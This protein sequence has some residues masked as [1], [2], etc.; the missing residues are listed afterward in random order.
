[1]ATPAETYMGVLASRTVAD[2]LIAQF[3]L[4][5]RYSKP[6]LYAT[7]IALKH[8]SRVEAARGSMIRISVEDR[9]ARRAAAMANAYVDALWRMNRRLALTTGSQRRL[10]FEQQVESERKP[11]ADAEEAFREIQQKTGVIQLAGQEELTLRSIAQIRAQIQSRELEVQ[12]LRTTATEQNTEVQRLESEIAGLKSQLQQA[13]GSA[14][15]ANDE[16]FVPAEK[17]PQAGLEYLRRARDLRYHEALFEM[18]SR[19]Y[20]QARVEEAKDPALIQ[21]VDQAIP[22][23]KRSW[24]PRTLLVQLAAV[25]TAFL[26]TGLVLLRARWRRVSE[27]PANGPHLMAIR[28]V[29][30]KGWLHW[31]RGRASPGDAWGKSG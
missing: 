4:E 14:G 31:G 7:R 10:F 3:D 5:K 1:M 21:V 20:E 15:D 19:Q 26:L 22:P 16:M 6:T 29:F 25:G 12:M 18:L 11:L 30:A 27:E 23:D 13:E 24:P 8:H 9:D 28:G 2:E 17:L